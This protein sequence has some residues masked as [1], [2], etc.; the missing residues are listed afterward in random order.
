MPRFDHG[1][2]TPEALT[3]V[4]AE[5]VSRVPFGRPA[6][7]PVDVVVER[8]FAVA[9]AV[10]RDDP[11]NAAA[12]LGSQ[13]DAEWLDGDPA[14]DAGPLTDSAARS[15]FESHPPGLLLERD[16]QVHMRLGRVPC[17]LSEPSTVDLRIHPAD[18]LA[19]LQE[20]HDEGAAASEADL[21]LA[22]TRL[23]TA[24]ADGA[25]R[26]ALDSLPVPV[27]TVVWESDR[28]VWY[29][30]DM[31]E[32]KS[33]TDEA[34]VWGVDGLTAG[35]AVA[36]YLDD[37]VVEPA[38]RT[39]WQTPHGLPRAPELGGFC[40]EPLVLPESL[41]VFPDRLRGFPHLYDPPLTAVFP[42]WVGD[43][44]LLDVHVPRGLGAGQAYVPPGQAGLVVRQLVRRA[45]PL[46]PGGA[47]NVLAAQRSVDPR[48]ASDTAVAVREAWERG[49][50]R[51]GVAD[52]ALLD[53]DG[54]PPVL[55]S[56]AQVLAPLAADG[57]LA[58]VWPVL[59]DLL[60]AATR[61]SRLMAGA[62]EVVQTIATLLPEVLHAVS[63]GLVGP[64]VL[65]L[66][67]TRALAT[68]KGAAQ[69]VRTAREVVV[70][71]PRG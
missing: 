60:V 51:P 59:D 32:L 26:A 63:T 38:C 31:V 19:R 11:Q 67:G 71:L 54:K 44:P 1:D 28:W 4:L 2:P 23:D 46:P 39:K 52:V 48:A 6:T 20:Y 64:D 42:T 49:L 34:Q 15:L 21:F 37:P 24:L 65:A 57:M 35:R 47:V 10:A 36:E 69:A 8:Y 22:L 58:V 5:L 29:R 33:G 55:A 27:V 7:T 45:T 3:Q 9:N 43:V 61:A 12:V 70:Q 53:W 25:I 17:L 41:Q 66:P 68:R 30:R 50:L 56:T 18:L 13:S 14:R 62:A 16:Q 40:S